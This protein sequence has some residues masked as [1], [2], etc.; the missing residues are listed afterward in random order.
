MVKY[1]KGKFGCPVEGTQIEGNNIKK[2]TT[3]VHKNACKFYNYL[4]IYKTYIKAGRK[5]GCC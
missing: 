1:I 2:Y 3:I 4:Y 5:W